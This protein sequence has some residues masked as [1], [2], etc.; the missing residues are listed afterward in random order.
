MRDQSSEE[1]F[2]FELTQAKMIISFFLSSFFLASYD[3]YPMRGEM[4][5]ERVYLNF[6]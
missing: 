1:E 5:C 2:K 4:L 3:A 6:K